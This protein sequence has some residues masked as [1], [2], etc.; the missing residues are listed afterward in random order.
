MSSENRF[1]SSWA[2]EIEWALAA[3]Y[4]ARSSNRIFKQ[5]HP[6]WTFLNPAYRSQSTRRPEELDL[7]IVSTGN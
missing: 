3:V 4:E 5:I 7:E 1:S 2:F 6:K